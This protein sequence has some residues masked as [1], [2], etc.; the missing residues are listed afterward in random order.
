MGELDGL[1]KVERA[2]GLLPP[3]LGVGKRISGARGYTYVGPVVRV[4]FRVDGLTLRYLPPLAAFVDLLEPD[5]ERF[6]GTATVAGRP[7]GRFTMSRITR[8]A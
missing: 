7:Y 6:L 4:P 3:L 5:G 2:G 1:W 8:A